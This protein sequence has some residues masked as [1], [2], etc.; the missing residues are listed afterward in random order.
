LLQ[1]SGEMSNLS[2]KMGCIGLMVETLLKYRRCIQPISQNKI[3]I[4]TKYCFM[5]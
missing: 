2:T 3:H 4:F 1:L 5:V